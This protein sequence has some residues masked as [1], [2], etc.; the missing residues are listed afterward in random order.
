MQT[1]NKVAQ[2]PEEFLRLPNSAWSSEAVGE[3]QGTEGASVHIQAI[4]A[5]LG[6]C[7]TCS[8]CHGQRGCHHKGQMEPGE[9]VELSGS[10][11]KGHREAESTALPL[12]TDGLNRSHTICSH[13]PGHLAKAHGRSWEG[14][15]GVRK[16]F[17]GL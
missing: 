16:G 11:Q 4:G 15:R 17:S 13:A 10:G 14:A 6:I 8:M 2:T 9:V 1:Q 7:Q 12:P 3:A 5:S